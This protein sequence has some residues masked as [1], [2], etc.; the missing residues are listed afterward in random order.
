PT[1]H[2]HTTNRQHDPLQVPQEPVG[3]GCGLSSANPTHI[4]ARGAPLGCSQPAQDTD[5]RASHGDGSVQDPSQR[6]AI[7][8]I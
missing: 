7:H 6:W 3:L 1:H 8:S 5:P 4:H 2:H